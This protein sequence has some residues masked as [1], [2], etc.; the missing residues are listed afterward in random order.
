MSQYGLSGFY[1]NCRGLRTQLQTLICNVVYVNY[2]NLTFPISV[3]II[4]L[5]KLCFLFCRSYIP[6][7]CPLTLYEQYIANIDIVLCK[8]PDHISIF[9]GDFKL[10]NVSWSNDDN[11][12]LFFLCL[13][14]VYL[15]SLR[16]SS[17]MVL[18]NS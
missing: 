15:V 2:A 3:L 11:R 7:Q 13:H 12:L 6:P 1:K 14:L 18:I 16:D 4:S 5:C 10:P 17:L 9:C 8:Y